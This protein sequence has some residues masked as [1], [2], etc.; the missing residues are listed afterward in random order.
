MFTN[1]TDF[2]TAKSNFNLENCSFNFS[3][4]LNTDG[5]KVTS[6]PCASGHYL[7]SSSTNLSSIISS[8]PTSG[9]ILLDITG[10]LTI[11]VNFNLPTGS[12]VIFGD[13]SGME[14]LSLKILNANGT[15][16][17]GCDDL[18]RS[19]HINSSGSGNFKDCTF[20]DGLHA[21]DYENKSLLGIANCDFNNNFVGVRLNNQS[22]GPGVIEWATDS[23][24]FINNRFYGGALLGYSGS[25]PDFILSATSTYAGVELNRIDHFH[26]SIIASGP[27][28]QPFL[29]N[30]EFRQGKF[31]ILSNESSLTIE[32]SN[33]GRNMVGIQEIASTPGRFVKILGGVSNQVSF[34]THSF[35]AVNISGFDKTILPMHFTSFDAPLSGSD[36]E[37][38]N[39][40]INS[41]IVPTLF[42][43][44]LEG[45]QQKQVTVNNNTFDFCYYG[46]NSE[47]NGMLN[48]YQVNSNQYN[49]FPNFIEA[50]TK[51]FFTIRPIAGVGV[52]GTV[53]CNNNTVSAVNSLYGI[54]CGSISNAQINNNSISSLGS[55]STNYEFVGV[56]LGGN[57]NY[58]VANNTVSG[59]GKNFPFTVAYA[60]L[61][62]T[63]T[64]FCNYSNAT[65]VGI[66]KFGDCFPS[67][68]YS[69][70]IH[71]HVIGLEMDF[72]SVIGLQDNHQNTWNNNPYNSDGAFFGPINFPNGISLSQFRIALGIPIQMH[73]LWPNPISVTIPSTNN[74]VGSWFVPLGVQKPSCS[75]GGDG[76]GPGSESVF[77][78]VTDQDLAIAKGEYDDEKSEVKWLLYWGLYEKLNRTPSLVDQDIAYSAFIQKVKSTN[79]DYIYQVYDNLHS[80]GKLDAVQAYRNHHESLVNQA[81]SVTNKMIE[82][83]NAK[84][85]Q[86]KEKLEEELQAEI[87]ALDAL[88][89]NNTEVTLSRDNALLDHANVLKSVL[90][91]VKN[92]MVIE[93]NFVDIYSIVLGHLGDIE[94]KIGGADLTKI[95]E[96]AEQCLMYGGRAVIEARNLVE[97]A[98]A[99]ATINDENCIVD[100]RNS[101]PKQENQATNA[102]S[103][104]FENPATDQMHYRI[105]GAKDQPIE[106]TIKNMSGELVYSKQGIDSS[107]IITTKNLAS[108]LY[109][110]ECKMGYHRLVE[111]LIIQ[112]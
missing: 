76:Q 34:N 63:G 66:R 18:W 64:S 103:L 65:N 82:L 71:D 57:S 43:L 75:A 11:D 54:E 104:V 49:Y 60:L 56:F 80:L 46:V 10:I 4:T 107:G 87:I 51:K 110:I 59:P 8:L 31:G 94:F 61:A 108:G 93:Q 58:M 52:G 105:S 14:V 37:M 84:N 97:L 41:T 27:G 74:G 100:I 21:L 95:V 99:K 45:L 47:G 86:D 15:S 85:N 106:I 38:R 7:V 111:K 12:D 40:I 88:Q 79:L 24:F 78:S 23:Y 39:V 13:N 70:K 89:D 91:S 33:F 53:Q 36:V 77:E 67:K 28:S 72:G 62:S 30:H 98:G 83:M 26:F 44:R 16:F 96:I 55:F 6:T 73:P 5:S 69:N 22:D 81:L 20:R 19:I 35:A 101:K 17:R 25:D 3:N 42:G 102:I 50:N 109:I 9:P 92:A 29:Y 1:A 48:T 32:R 112:K 2:V 90:N 68:V